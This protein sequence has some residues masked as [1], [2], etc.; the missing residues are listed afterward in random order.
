MELK[1]MLLRVETGLLRRMQGIHDPISG[2][3]EKKLEYFLR[4]SPFEQ[5]LLGMQNEEVRYLR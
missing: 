2:M 4:M 5:G 1:H 3:S